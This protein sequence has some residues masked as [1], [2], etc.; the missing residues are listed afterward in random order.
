MELALQNLER[1][2]MLFVGSKIVLTPE[3]P[4]PILIDIDSLTKEEAYQVLYN[5][6][7]GV[8]TSKDNLSALEKKLDV[9]AVPAPVITNNKSNKKE[10]EL[11]KLLAKRIATI[12][13][14]VSDFNVSDLKKVIDLEKSK[15]NR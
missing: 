11:N 15:K 3:N 10:I 5:I 8:L 14:E 6:R 4:G 12:K 9:Q 1:H 13:K 2:S 7:M